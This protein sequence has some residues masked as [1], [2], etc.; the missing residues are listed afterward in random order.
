MYFCQIHPPSGDLGLLVSLISGPWKGIGTQQGD[1]PLALLFSELRQGAL[2]R[3]LCLVKELGH[4]PVGEVTP[5]YRVD[6][7]GTSLCQ[8]SLPGSGIFP[9]P[10]NEDGLPV[11]SFPTPD[12]K[13]RHVEDAWP[14]VAPVCKEEPT[15]RLRASLAR[16]SSHARCLGYNLQ[17]N[18]S[19]LGMDWRIRQEWRQGWVKRVD[20]V[21][22]P[23]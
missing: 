7:V 15:P 3:D 8:A 5:E 11:P 20:A 17:R 4:Q 22:E 23:L 10:L 16:A 19:Q 2:A 6:P 1:E 13:V 21:A 9:T 18:S 12:G 14:R